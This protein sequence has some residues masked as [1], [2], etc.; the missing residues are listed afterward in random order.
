M[1]KYVTDFID[2]VLVQIKYKKAHR[3][4]SEELNNHI[5]E[6]ADGY[7]AEGI[8][9][10][11]AYCKAVSQMGDPIEIGKRLHKTHKPKT[12]WSIIAL[13]AVIVG[14]GLYIITAYSYFSQD[15][16]IYNQL[17]FVGIGISIF[18]FCYF[19]DYTRLEKYS[20][21]TFFITCVIFIMCI[22]FGQKFQGRSYI[23]FFRFRFEPAL[24]VIPILLICYS[25]MVKKWCDG[26]IKNMVK[27]ISA[28]ALPLIIML[29]EP[30]I[31][32]T[33]IT[34]AGF[35]TMLTFGVFRSNYKGNRR[36]SL[37][38]IYGGLFGLAV[39]MFIQMIG[40]RTYA[41]ERFI[42]FFNQTLHDKDSGWIY[43]RLDY[44]ISSAKFIGDSGNVTFIDFSGGSLPSFP[45]ANSEFILTFVIGKLGWLFGILLM[46]LLCLIILRMFMASSRVRNE[47]GKYL[48]VGIC[49]VFSFEV[50]LNV[51]MNLGLFIPFSSIVRPFI[52]YGG[53]NYLLNMVLLGLFLGVYRRKDI[54]LD[55]NCFEK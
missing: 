2:T 44:I 49:C 24:L 6:L 8:K 22:M 33:M 46:A 48:C 26:Q 39:L 27:L 11:E 38:I 43:S 50:I 35:L 53:A 45:G 52:S 21:P 17:L 13:L 20:L 5:C 19:F 14:Y 41:F 1:S 10:D 36:K 42:A 25:G 3:T 18:V 54:V 7:M 28:S 31:I 30:S 9:E 16:I 47:F 23:L 4:I 15:K 51:L 34:G 32:N 29:M 12:E 55:K 37:L 40:S